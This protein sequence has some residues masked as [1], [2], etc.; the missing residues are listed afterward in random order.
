M[1]K[2][3]D[4]MK[5]WMDLDGTSGAYTDTKFGATLI[6]AAKCKD[7]TCE[8]DV[9]AA[10]EGACKTKCAA[11][12]P[13]S[14]TTKLPVKVLAAGKTICVAA[15]WGGANKCGLCHT[16]VATAGTKD[17]AAGYSCFPRAKSI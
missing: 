13:W 4:A 16:K 8:A 5:A 11:L 6:A 1:G 17:S 2:A 15:Q 14:Y 7:A 9:A 10:D 3:V 12:P